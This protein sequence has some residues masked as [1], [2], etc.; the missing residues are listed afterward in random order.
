MLECVGNSE[1]GTAFR[2]M[3]VNMPYLRIQWILDTTDVPDIRRSGLTTIRFWESE[4]VMV[5]SSPN[6]PMTWMMSSTST[7]TSVLFDK[8]NLI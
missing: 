5:P 2:C 3:S 7:C 1:G 4:M 6:S 8:M